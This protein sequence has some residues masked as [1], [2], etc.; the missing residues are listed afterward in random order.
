[1]HK[2]LAVP[3]TLSLAALVLAAVPRPA[4]AQSDDDLRSER[5]RGRPDAPVT[6][7]EISDFQCPYCGEFARQTLPDIER[8]YVVTGK[9][10]L[11]FVNMPLPIHPNAEPA[12]ELA[13]CAA[14]QH[15]FWQMHDLLFRHQSQWAELQDPGPYLLS[16]GD[17]I[18]A[19][20]TEL[21][22]CLT[23]KAMRALVRS[24]F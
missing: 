17:S 4:A 9:V 6:V 24:D 7:Y 3:G 11:I 20:R 1:M 22:T 23:T 21:E 16:F 19:N 14:R 18:R 15:K 2:W 13:M 5:T 10:K 8:E 12:A